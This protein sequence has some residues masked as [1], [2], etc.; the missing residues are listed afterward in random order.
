MNG[1][2]KWLFKVKKSNSG[3]T[4]YLIFFKF[5]ILTAAG[6]TGSMCV[7][8]PNVVMIGQPIGELS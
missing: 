3:R 4:P 6:L 5:D 8:L 7:I 2:G 1:C